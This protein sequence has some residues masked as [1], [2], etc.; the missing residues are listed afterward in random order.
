MRRL[1]RILLYLYPV[2][3]R[4]EYAAPME[5]QF[6]DEYRDARGWGGRALLTLRALADLAMTAPV[7]AAR[8]LWQ[9][10][11]YAARV[12]RQRSLAAALAVTAL[13]LAIGVTT[14]IFS[15]LNALLIRSLPF[16]EPERLVEFSVS[17]VNVDGRAA[18]R[19]WVHDSRYLE[20]AASFDSGDLNLNLAGRSARVHVAETSANFLRMLGTE[21]EFGRGFAP[22]EDTP[23]KN[24]VAVIGYGLW[25]QLFGG[26]PR[27]LGATIRLN[28]VPLTVIGVAPRGFD[29]PETTAVWTPTAHELGRIPKS[30]AF[31]WQT[32][33]RLKRGV[34]LAQA[35]HMFEAEVAR[36]GTSM[37]RPHVYLLR[38]RLAG[39]VQAASLVLMGMA[40]FVLLIACANVAHLLV[41]R[42]TERS[43]ELAVRAALGASRARLMQQLITE[44]IVLTAA[45]A[46][47]GMVVAHW[48]ARLAAAVQPAQF[49]SRQYTVLDWRVIA[50]ATALTLFMGVALGMVPALLA[51]RRRIQA[52]LIATQVALTVALAAG[53]FSLGRGF[54]KLLGT[55]LAFRTDRMVTLNVSLS[56]TRH[57]AESRQRQYYGEALG[58]LRA[59]PGVQSA[60][61]VSYL[62]LI[63]RQAFLGSQSKLESGDKQQLALFVAASPGYF[64]A[65]GTEVME[66]R[67]FTASDRE[68][69][70]PVAVIS[71]G[72]ER[73]F[74]RGP[75]VGRK[76]ELGWVQGGSHWATI[77]G[78][79]RAERYQGPVD[80][81]VDS[82]IFVPIEQ[83][84][85]GFVTFVA[86][87]RGDPEAYLAA[88]RDAVQRT[89]PE[90]PVYDVKTL[91]RRLADA[92]AR[93]KFYTTAILFFAGFALLLAVA[94]I[95][96]VATYSVA[97]RTREIGVRI[98][99]GASPARVRGLLL[100][101]SMAPAGVG[102]LAGAA[103]AVGS[104]RFLRHLVASVEPPG[105]WICV[106]AVS[107]MA[108]S[109]AAVWS[110][111]GRVVRM[112]PTAAL[113]V[114]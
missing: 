100:R 61:A 78:V 111:T 24:G 10:V 23:G 64:R 48:T 59:V 70:E 68:G 47:A 81:G 77:V 16:R 54:L 25:Q 38:D 82:Q 86:R 85:P 75:L 87:V 95:Y 43:H 96:G 14:G 29:Y 101:Q 97:R 53:S 76:I 73:A 18:F 46:L 67:E 114:E 39:P 6:G 52:V 3:F 22:D 40:A 1:Y 65:M 55:D 83:S 26:D 8:E 35:S 108:A 105:L 20:D 103:A 33:G 94:G 37:E 12:H 107:V 90:V 13:A 109:A 93:P 79:V 58:R 113:K 11:R 106:I 80:E 57:E 32:I 28:G 66:G 98:A 99:V 71:D 91:D 104:G 4:E 9:D 19:A 60:A 92:L 21:P 88:C 42:T 89:D 27:A 69:S 41:A 7:E 36:V 112:D 5:R 50:F 72:L 84:P 2:R 49:S 74:G 34:S 110:A 17:P 102:M 15:V 45:A 56:G 63:V 31:P 51:G 44:A 62:P 30:G